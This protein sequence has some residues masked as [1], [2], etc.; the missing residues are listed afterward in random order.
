LSFN[1]SYETLSK[2]RTGDEQLV[3]ATTS[4]KLYRHG[5]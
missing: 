1:G 4:T 3:V 5:S 2:T